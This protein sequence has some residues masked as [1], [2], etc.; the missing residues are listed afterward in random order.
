MYH[1]FAGLLFEL[2]KSCIMEYLKRIQFAWA[3]TIFFTITHHYLI[4]NQC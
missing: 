1:F 3:A 2:W 4:S